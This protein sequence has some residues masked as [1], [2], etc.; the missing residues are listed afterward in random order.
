MVKEK[1]ILPKYF[2]IN[3]SV[4]KLLPYKETCLLERF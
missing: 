1:L 2:P 4:K 3:R